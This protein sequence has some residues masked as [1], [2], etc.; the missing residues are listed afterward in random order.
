[1]CVELVKSETQVSFKPELPLEEQICGCQEAIIDCEPDC[2]KV[3]KFLAEVEKA[4]QYGKSLGIKLS[5][6]DT[7]N[8]GLFKKV[9]DLNQAIA[10][11]D[12]IHQI[13]LFH[14]KADRRLEEI[15]NMCRKPNE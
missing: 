6:V 9:K 14:D 5:L 12:I 11:S 4:C 2:P 1:M 13:V 8:F 15:A 10:T 7:H 3:L